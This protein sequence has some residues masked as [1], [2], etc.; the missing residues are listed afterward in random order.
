VAFARL[1]S[2]ALASQALLS[3]ASFGVGLILIRHIADAQYGLYILATNTILLVSSLQNAL[4]NPPLAN[5]AARLDAPALGRFV[6]GLFREQRRLIAALACCAVLVTGV[7]WRVGLLPGPVALLCAATVLATLAV[8]YREFFR[9][10]LY[11]RRDARTVLGRDVL[12]AM[13]LVAGALFASITAL[14][15]VSAMLLIGVAATASG[16]LLA[17]AYRAAAPWTAPG[18]G[19]VLRSVAPLALW[20]TAGAA[21]HWAFSQGYL[22]VVAG[23]LDMSAVAAIAA[24]RLVMMPVNLLS[25]GLG[26]LMLPL[27]CSWLQRHGMPRLRRRLLAGAAALGFATLAYF[28]LLWNARTWVFGAVLHK[29]VPELDRLLALWGAIVFVMVTRDQLSYLMSAAGRFRA[30][31]LLTL[32]C[33]VLSLLSGYAA[34]SRLGAAGALTGLLLGETLSVAG[35]LVMTR[36]PARRTGF[37]AA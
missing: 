5:R 27:A 32:G 3:A 21:I 19:G 26:S 17:R 29:Q 13:L 24:T 31:T 10:V 7:L 9:M 11:A 2:G 35:I 12:H 30:L 14:P 6:S 34:M 15:A 33:A 25:A 36:S 37:A 20:S 8:L 16:L 4:L 1:L 18:E 28:A 23:T 22:F